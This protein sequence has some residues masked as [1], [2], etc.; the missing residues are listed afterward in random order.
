MGKLEKAE[1][2]YLRGF[3]GE[4][5]KRRTGLSVQSTLKR[6]RAIGRIYTKTDII[7]HQIEYISSRYTVDE[8]ISAYEQI[9]AQYPDLD[10]AKRAKKIEILGCGFGDY[11]R[12]FKAIIGTDTYKS[13]RDKCWKEKQTRTVRERFGVDNV[14]EKKVFDTLADPEK[15]AE[16]RRKRTETML[17]RYGVEQPNQ[18]E[19]IK[20]RMLATWTDTNMER[21]GVPVAMQDL[22]IARKS[23]MHR[24][25]TMIA[26]YGAANSVQ[27]PEIRE[28]IFS[29]RAAHG[30]LNTSMPE[31]ALYEMLVAR[32]GVGDVIRN[33]VID[34]RYPYHVDFYIRSRDLFIE[35]NGD[36][37]HGGHWFDINSARDCQIVRSWSGNADRIRLDTGRPSRYEKYIITW[38]KTDVE[39]RSAA[40]RMSLNYLVFWDSRKIVRHKKE[41][42]RLKD[43]REWFDAG[44]PDSKD[45][46][47]ENTY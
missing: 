36:K 2:F 35:L 18:N 6:L 39:K 33:A 27:V 9:S 46:L 42:P 20:Q 40:A 34:R 16:G 21:Y 11:P 24:Q 10:M 32:F 38:T 37:C 25:E 26:R 29:N 13:L 7:R 31:D 1:E 22:T 47:P 12:V 15:I 43:A 41:F 45:W 14:F 19:D 5:I 28:K 44:C 8:V 4:Y 3:N 30:T 17:A 23:A